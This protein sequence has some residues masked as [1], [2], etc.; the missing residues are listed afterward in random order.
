M[1]SEQIIEEKKDYSAYK[2]N[3]DLQKVF[4]FFVEHPALGIFLIYALV[5][6]ASFIY[7]LTFYKHFNL[8]II[9]YLEISDILVACIK[10]PNVLATVAIIF[11]ILTLI[12]YSS[13]LMAPFNAWLDI[14]FGKGPL[15]FL[16]FMFGFKTN[17]YFWRSMLVILVFYLVV[18]IHLH[19]D[20]KAKNIIDSKQNLINIQS[21]ATTNADD[22]YS[23]LG[24]SINYIFLYDHESKSPLIV[25][26]ESIQ[27]LRPVTAKEKLQT[28]IEDTSIK[29]LE[30]ENLENT[31]K[32][33]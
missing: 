21:D 29:V 23:L 17:S 20:K 18:F 32:E 8:E 15:K 25:P 10:D 16:V 5:A 11:I 22:Q 12:Y 13:R 14:K 19:S 31:K 33:S 4:Q 27:S 28:P 30:S 26:L 7:L 3:A 9:S 24:T 6:T 1:E 2:P